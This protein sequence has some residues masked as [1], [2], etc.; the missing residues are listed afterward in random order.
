[1][2]GT[3]KNSDAVTSVTLASDGAAAT[4]AYNAAGYPITAS[5]AQGTGLANYTTISRTFPAL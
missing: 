5:N 3:L 4:A 2:T 1:M